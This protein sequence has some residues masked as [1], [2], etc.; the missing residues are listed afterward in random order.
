MRMNAYKNRP[1]G[2]GSPAST[3]SR[4]SRPLRASGPRRPASGV[5]RAAWAWG[6][7]ALGVVLVLLVATA[8][9]WLHRHPEIAPRHR[10]EALCFLLARARFNPPMRIEPS[11]AMVRG[12][13]G[14]SITAG[15]AIREV[16]NLTD[17]MVL[18]EENRRIGDYSVSILWLRLPGEDPHT[19]WMIVGWM[20][21]PDL[22]VCNFRFAGGS[23]ELSDDER[24]WGRL[25]Q[26]RILRDEYFR[27]GVT[28]MVRLRV[29]N[30]AQ[31]PSFGPTSPRG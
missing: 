14:A 22:A 20:E 24:G 31:M 5:P 2:I 13:F 21:G 8:A 18:S 9:A 30:G 27:A 16:M 25:L 23:R 15:Y 12:R 29:V 26:E 28:P 1:Q 11:A 19:H 6:F 4:P 7:G 3:A 10:P 17:R